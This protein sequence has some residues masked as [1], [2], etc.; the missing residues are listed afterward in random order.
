MELSRGRLAQLEERPV[1][2]GEVSGSSPLSPME[3]PYIGNFKWKK[4]TDLRI[5]S[6][7]FFKHKKA[8]YH[9]AF[10]ISA[11]TEKDEVL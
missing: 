1:H 8:P 3:Y 2:I 9:G 6:V 5:N 11:T 7:K 4:K 10:F